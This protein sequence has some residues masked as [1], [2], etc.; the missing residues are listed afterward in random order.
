MLW[1]EEVSG[2]ARPPALGAGAG[3]LASDILTSIL[4]GAA[5]SLL[6][7]VAIAPQW[8]A[9]SGV[10]LSW[11]ALGGIALLG[12]LAG[13]CWKAAATGRRLTLVEAGSDILATGV[14]VASSS[15]QTIWQAPAAWSDL[16]RLSAAGATTYLLLY[17]LAN[18]Y[19]LTAW[20]SHLSLRAAAIIVATPYFFG[21]LLALQSEPLAASLGGLLTFGLLSGNAAFAAMI[22]R[23]LLLLVFVEFIAAAACMANG[24][25]LLRSGRAHVYL[26]LIAA[27]AIVAPQVADLGSGAIAM[28]IPLRPLAAFAATVLS[29]GALWALV[30]LL[31]GLTLDATRGKTPAPAS[32]ER[33]AISGAKKGMVFSGILI[34]ILVA[35]NAVTGW[36]VIAEAYR[37]APW[38]VL[39]LAGAVAFPLGKTII[40]S[41]D[42][43][44]A[45]FRRAGA[46]YRRPLLWARGAAI[47]LG[48][49][50]ALHAGLL[51]L[52]TGE[53]VTIGL[54]VG[55]LAYAGVSLL[56]DALLW[57]RGRG[58]VRSWRPYLV[59]ALLGGFIG[60]ALGF[61]F[62]ALQ[63]PV[64][65]D[66]IK[67]YNSFGLNPVSDEFYPLLSKWGRISLAPYAGGAKLL[68]NEAL[69]G[70]VGWGVAAWLF[71]LNR[72]VLLAIFQR[73]TAPLRRIISRDG[74]T[75]LT[76]G[77][78]HVLRWGLW[79]APII[80]TFLR[81]M[82]TPTWYNQDGAIH[83]G[84][85]I[86][87][88][89]TMTPEHFSHWSLTVFTWLMGYDIFR[90]LIWLDH[91]GLRV[92][93]L[94]N[95]SFLGMDRLDEA[96]ARFVRP[97]A[98]ARLFPEGVKRFTT[99]APLLIP[100]YI[101]TGRD[102]DWAWTHAEQ[103]QQSSHGLLAPLVAMP[104]ARLAWLALATVAAA[105][106]AS[107]LL[108]RVGAMRAGQRA[109][110]S[111][112]TLSGVR[113]TVTARPSGELR[114]LLVP[115][116]FDLS[117][118][119]YEGLDPAGRALFLAEPD[120]QCA[121]WPVV[122][123][124][125]EELFTRSR[126]DGDAASLR[127]TNES[128]GVRATIVVRLPD[129]SEVA[130][131][132]WEITLENL[133]NRTR[134]LKVAPYLE[135]VLAA[136]AADRNHTQYNR[137]FIETRYE[138]KLNAVLAWHRVSKR[139][140]LLAA[141]RTP[142]GFLT[143][144]VDFIGRAGS[145]WTPDCL[146]GPTGERRFLEPRATRP[147]PTFD[148]IGSLMLDV[149][150]A[151]WGSASLS[152]LI[153]CAASEEEAADWVQR[154]LR[155]CNATHKAA[156]VGRVPGVLL[157]R[158]ISGATTGRGFMKEPL[159]FPQ[160][161]THTPQPRIGHG[162]VP[163]GTPQPYC[164]F[165]DAGRRLRVRTPLTPRPFDHTM[166]NAQGHVLS[167]TNRGLHSS[168]SVNAQQNRITTDWADTVTRELPS[169]AFYLYDTDAK[170]WYSPTY[171]PL[172]DTEASY[173]SEFS[174]DGTAVFRMERPE[175]ATELTVFVPPEEPAGVYLLS[176]TNRSRRTQ[177]L[178]VCPYFEIAL[179]DQ[180]ENAG[181]LTLAEDRAGGVVY[182]ENPRNTFRTGPAF[183]AISC[184]VERLA[185]RRG[186]FF[187]LGRSVA[188][189]KF[190]EAPG[191]STSETDDHQPIA[192]LLASLEIPAGESATI[193]VVLGQTDDRRQ[194][195]AATERLCNVAGA[196]ASLAETR[197]WWNGL[198]DTLQVESS[199]AAFDGYLH[200]L[201]Y[202]TLAERIW[203]RKGFYQASGAFGFRDQLQ[204]AV[205]LVWV[206]PAMARRQILLNAAQ[207]F[208][209]GDVVHWFFRLQ[210]GRT[211]FSFR[212][213]ASDNL[214]WLGWA[215]ADYVR[216]TGDRSILDERAPYLTAE[217]PLE[218]LPEGKQ[219]MGLFP[220]RSTIEEPL[221]DHVLRA[222]DLVLDHRMG[223]HGLPLMGA[224]D[225]NDG[226]DEIGSQGRGES[227]WL[228]MF[229]YS[230]LDRLMPYIEEKK[231]PPR[232]AQYQRK[233]TAL[234]GALE[235]MW[236]GD[237][238][239]RAI[240]D[241]GTEIGL[242]GTGTWEIDALTA[243]WAVIAGMDPQRSRVAFETAIRLLERDK[244]ILLGWPP[245][246]EDSKPYLGRS[247]RYPEGVRENGMYCHGVQWLVKA[248]RILSERCQAACDRQGA[249]LYRDAA[250]RLW[251]K[252]SPL[253]RATPGEI[254][255]YGGQ[256]NKQAAD[257][258]TAFEPGRMIWNGYTGAAGWMLRQACEAVIGASLIDNHVI[259]P[260]DFG[261][262]R[263]E[264]TIH[265]L[266]RRLDTSPLRKAE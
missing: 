16:L 255:L 102:W 76:D 73:T 26:T 220:L 70:V 174:V 35:V 72:S 64:V 145:V 250:V 3:R 14:L 143:S 259:L 261:Q 219:G 195:K 133:S 159:S 185:T 263:D 131:E 120:G 117:R 191:S 48:V 103:I 18:A 28:P 203:A 127:V 104:V 46:A 12:G 6:A 234:R 29:Q 98:T 41:F 201:K 161:T 112:H 257:M 158:G 67:L 33:H 136:A 5:A 123:N 221:L 27:A 206:D 214:L 168:A 187:G 82:P 228:G 97:A 21:T 79:M 2:V 130:A 215:A 175:I 36:P 91:M 167:V 176:I 160:G 177:R 44:Q 126:I 248:A 199:D 147:A 217:T 32:I 194:A 152:L 233:V 90:V 125:P 216:M 186:D 1:R 207:Q 173:A 242:P 171:L 40:E 105:S 134:S 164:E 87:N 252:I 137:L 9:T 153:G 226:L 58:R 249:R 88:N 128:N 135:W 77:T 74:M 156:T 253:D 256:P 183:A 184:P 141:D 30:F 162:R 51:R 62:D 109:T 106:V 197:A 75:E 180:P 166:A 179:A 243:A 111:E 138:P 170:R 189:P 236:R 182:F 10:A 47:G 20:K 142:T 264:F 84:F 140:G 124:F 115:E 96:A 107:F 17:H 92:A 8:S 258:L 154:Y 192:A 238:Y 188:H 165:G 69:K 212:S 63:S 237:R 24:Q 205:N 53:R 129:P 211:G 39:A 150:L 245:L 108:R 101:P 89:I 244:V 169:E 198:M 116:E 94:V 151:P 230:I 241:D 37:A 178:R 7:A 114:S 122:G 200:W 100:F 61:Y 60:A 68:F 38:L 196:R 71:A 23:T 25:R 93:T 132:R 213:H 66:K 81:Q 222:I 56:S 19:A 146:T 193:A 240:H 251:R 227:V 110:E 202:Q 148:P 210:D 190:V 181:P 262:M 260:D 11:L 224:G 50:Y 86:V 149:Q 52:P 155:P 57:L 22:G 34:A 266:T 254:D 204:D 218:P 65:L 13:Q 43:S 42:G 246:R 232:R 163:A 85:C 247:C 231:G 157:E 95:L 54:A 239:L 118:R 15:V 229:L 225:W 55:V 59:E 78:I 83:T 121:A 265:T 80:F 49:W 31:T 208:L 144:R 139:L 45:F 209:E 4:F 113:Y 172:R 223:S 235:A 99:W 119:S